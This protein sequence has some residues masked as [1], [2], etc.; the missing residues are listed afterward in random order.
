MNKI[1]KINTKFLVILIF[2]II[3]LLVFN[4]SFVCAA[5]DD[6]LNFDADEWSPNNGGSEGN[7]IKIIGNK[8]IGPVQVLGSLISVIAIIII[9]VKYMF[10]SV[11]EK[12]QYKE[13]LLPYLLGAVFVF[14]ITNIVTIIY[15]VASSFN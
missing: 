11:E 4:N 6:F 2:F 10:G 12:A 15:K 14:G 13:T 5:E 7:E 8:I 3:L 9:G 1:I